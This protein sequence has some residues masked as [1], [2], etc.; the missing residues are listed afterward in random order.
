MSRGIGL[1]SG[2]LDSILAVKVIQEQG[3][4]VLGIAFVTPFFGAERAVEAAEQL[5]IELRVMDIS[6]EHLAMVKAPAHG[7]GKTMNPCIDC[8]TLMLKCAGRVM[9]AEGYDF[10]FTGEVLGERPMSQNAG[11]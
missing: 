10:L 4:E 1:V 8:H 7:Y 9:E 11:R 6:E 2:G 3:I 5:G